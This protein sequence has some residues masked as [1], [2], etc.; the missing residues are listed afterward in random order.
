[1]LFIMQPNLH[2]KQGSS[3][4]H[5]KY[6]LATLTLNHYNKYILLILYHF[7]C[8]YSIYNVFYAHSFK[9]YKFCIFKFSLTTLEFVRF[10]FFY[11]FFLNTHFE[12]EK[13][14]LYWNDV[15]YIL[16]CLGGIFAFAHYRF[17]R[18]WQFGGCCR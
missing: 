5:A 6:F 1:M 13:E 15:V 7:L 16:L 12:N 8:T 11:F 18:Y 4:K 14:K 10:Q 3:I 17:P 2:F 9:A